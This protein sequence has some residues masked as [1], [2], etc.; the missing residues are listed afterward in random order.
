MKK[1]VAIIM[2]LLLC[3]SFS[4]CKEKNINGGQPSIDINYFLGVGQ[5]SE[6]K[7]AIGNNPDAI[8]RDAEMQKEQHNHE[9]G[10]GHEGIISYEDYNGKEAY[11]VD[12]FYYCFE[13]GTEAE[14][15]SLIIG[16]DT[17]YGFTAGISTKFEINSALSSMNPENVKSG[18]EDFFYMPFAMEDVDTLVCKNGNM[19]LKFYFEN[20]IMISAC[21]YNSDK[22]EF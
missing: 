14:G 10:D 12:G 4:A 20:D 5:I 18:S 9:G 1:A 2:A 17:V 19:V 16:T 11:I 22:W 3:L 21:I 6:A 7:Y 13:T 8:E 15:I